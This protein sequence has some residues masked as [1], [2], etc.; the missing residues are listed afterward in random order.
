MSGRKCKLNAEI[1]SKVCEALR[2]GCTRKIAAE[3]AGIS[4][5]TLYSWMKR[6]EDARSGRFLQFLQA[7]QGAEARGAVSSLATIQQAAR[8]GDWRAAAWIL[9]RRHNYT[10]QQNHIQVNVDIDAENI[11]VRQLL[12]NVQDNQEL[13]S[14]LQPTLVIDEKE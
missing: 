11:D 3:Y 13:L 8:S 5:R 10:T 4:E 14:S 6:G 1:Q 2:V 7:V 9:E 12:Q